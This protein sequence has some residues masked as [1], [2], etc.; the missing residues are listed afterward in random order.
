MPTPASPSPPRRSRRTGAAAGSRGRTLLALALAAQATAAIG[1]IRFDPHRHTLHLSHGVQATPATIHQALPRGPVQPVAGAPRGTWLLSSHLAIEGGSA[2]LLRGP[3]AGGEVVELRLKSDNVDEPHNFVGVTAD[4]GL[5]DI[6]ATRVTSWDRVAGGPDEEFGR[7]GRAFLRVRSRLVFDG[8]R[9]L[10]SR[11]DVVDSDV[12]YLGYAA[13]EAYGLAWKATGAETWGYGSV[14]VRGDVTG[15]RIHHNYFGLYS[16]GAQ[17]NVWRD[18]EVFGNVQYG[19]APHNHSDRL[20]IE[21][22][23]VHHN[24]THGIMV[25]KECDDLVIRGNR[26]WA[27]ARHGI[28]VR[29]S[30]NRA[31]VAD[32]TA[33]G[34]GEAGIAIFA[35]AGARLLGNLVLRNGVTGIELSGGSAGAEVARN[36]LGRNGASALRVVRGGDAPEDGSDGRPRR[37]HFHDNFVHGTGGAAVRL[38]Q[39][40]GTRFTAN[41][42]EGNA[43]I[44]DED[45][46]TGTVLADNRVR[47]RAPAATVDT[48]AAAADVRLVAQPGVRF[49]RDEAPRIRGTR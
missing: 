22:N 8:R 21:D 20:R 47:P 38:A 13:A 3:A 5:I 16:F 31:L 17:G 45:E 48:I 43:A 33:F 2:L 10:E 30:S 37:N 26:V 39:A 24:G 29:R 35:S 40:D 42:F 49:V 25:W 12:G 4:H 18:N 11:M 41:L 9:A 36:E 46:A 14:A 19:I 1:G 15:S 32:N 34:N 28:F 7:F 23:R 6:R 27:N 44:L